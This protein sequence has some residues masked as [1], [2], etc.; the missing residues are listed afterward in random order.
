MLAEDF[1]EYV[2]TGKAKAG[3]PKRNSL[4]RKI[5]NFIR[6]LFGKSTVTETTDIKSVKDLF[7]KLYIGGENL[8]IYTPSIDNVMFDILNRNSGIVKPGT[9]T[10]QVLNRQDSNLLNDSMDSIISEIIDDQSLIRKNKAGTLSIL[11]D[12]RNREP[13]Y[14]RIKIKLEARLKLINS[15]L[16]EINALEDSPNNQ[17]KRE[18]AENRLRIINTVN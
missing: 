14:K 16:E 13:L 15:Q 1:R 10:D 2:R 4:F 5:L 3:S 12:S 17:F 11:L 7:D 6:G 18:T 8:N 9:E